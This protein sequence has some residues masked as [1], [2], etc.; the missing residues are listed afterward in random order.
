MINWENN[1][2]FIAYLTVCFVSLV[3]SC[4]ASLL[5]LFVGWQVKSLTG[6]VLIVFSMNCAQIIYAIPIFF[7]NICVIY[8]DYN[9]FI[10]CEA[11]SMCAGVVST[12]L[13]N[14]LAFVAVYIVY[15]RQ[16]VDIIKYF[17]RILFWCSFPGIIIAIAYISVS[18]PE[19]KVNVEAQVIHFPLIIHSWS[20]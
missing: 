6:H 14:V 3:I 18:Y 19:A 4:V 12:L 8:F 11:V 20:I 5:A 17:V 15:Y 1:E 13:S 9:Q 7:I 16:S 10:I 2:K